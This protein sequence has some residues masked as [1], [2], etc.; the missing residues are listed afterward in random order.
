[1]AALLRRPE[2]TTRDFVTKKGLMLPPLLLLF[3]VRL[4]TLLA[5]VWR[6]LLPDKPRSAT[7]RCGRLRIVIF[8]L[9][10]MGDVVMTTPFFRELKRNYPNSHCT[11]V[12]QHAFRPLL[13]TNPFLDEVLTLPEIAAPWLLVAPRICWPLCCCIGGACAR[14]RI[15][16]RFRLAGTLTSIWRHCCACSPTPPSASATARRLR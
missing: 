7:P 4:P 1:M 3:S 5:K 12:V 9:D 15:T 13:V 10:A 14:K 11:A 2:L 16:S 6:A 8:R